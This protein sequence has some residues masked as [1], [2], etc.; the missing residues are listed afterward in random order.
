MEVGQIFVPQFKEGGWHFLFDPLC[1]RKVKDESRKKLK[2]KVEIEQKLK[3]EMMVEM[4]VAM[5]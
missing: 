2:V 1:W 4:R 5:K 3:V